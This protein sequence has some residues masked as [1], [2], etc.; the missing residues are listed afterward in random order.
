MRRLILLLCLINPAYAAKKPSSD[1]YVFKKKEYEKTTL[2]VHVH[3]IDDKFDFAYEKNT[4]QLRDDDIEA[5]SILRPRENT[6][7]IFIKNPEWKYQPEYIGH[8]LTHC[9][10][11]RWH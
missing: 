11:G 7:T 4:H 9:I 5:F 10:W 8:E 2:I 6:C 1:G 3:I